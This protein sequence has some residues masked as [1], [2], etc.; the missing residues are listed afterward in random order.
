V[1]S[2]PS[3]VQS[4]EQDEFTLVFDDFDYDWYE[5]GDTREDPRP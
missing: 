4:L 5:E 1:P 3:G 2:T